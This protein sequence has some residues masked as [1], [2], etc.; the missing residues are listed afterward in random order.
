MS[1]RTIVTGGFGNGTFNGSIADVVTHGYTAGVAVAV[2][3]VAVAPE[4]VGGWR[5]IP[6]R[7]LPAA[8]ELVLGPLFA[9][10]F[11]S[12]RFN[13]F[14]YNFEPLRVFSAICLNV[15]SPIRLEAVMGEIALR[16]LKIKGE[17][18]Q[19]RWQRELAMVKSQLQELE[20]IRILGL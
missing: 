9:E 4:V 1:I 2:P 16:S 19:H 14:E 7:A 3:S 12:I 8:Y 18:G 5:P 15:A 6:L 11:G 17:W 13:R 20:D 10:T